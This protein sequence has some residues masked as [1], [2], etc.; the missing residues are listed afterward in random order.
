M[1]CVNITKRLPEHGS[2]LITDLLQYDGVNMNWEACMSGVSAILTLLAEVPARLA[3]ANDPVHLPATA[4]VRLDGAGMW[5]WVSGNDKAI[6]HGTRGEGKT[7]QPGHCIAWD[8]KPSAP[9]VTSTTSHSFSPRS[10]SGL[11]APP[12][13]RRITTWTASCPS[14]SRVGG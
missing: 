3:G 11:A 1:L 5:E 10:W 13:C 14:L 6:V 2:A 7:M 4:G 9:D 12:G 8:P